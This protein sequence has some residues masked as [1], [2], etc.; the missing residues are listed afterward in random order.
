[1]FFKQMVLA[2]LLLLHPTGPPQ[3]TFI[4]VTRD[5]LLDCPFRV[6]SADLVIIFP[7]DVLHS[8]IA[9]CLLTALLVSLLCFLKGSFLF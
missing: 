4:R 8:I 5:F 6:W 7:H 1:M 3:P 2:Y 9:I